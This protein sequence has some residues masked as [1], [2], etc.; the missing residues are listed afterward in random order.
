M[1]FFRLMKLF[2]NQCFS[3]KTFTRYWKNKNHH[4]F[5]PIYF[6]I[7]LFIKCIPIVQIILVWSCHEGWRLTRTVNQ[8]YIWY[9]YDILSSYAIHMYVTWYDITSIMVFVF[10]RIFEFIYILTP[11]KR[12]NTIEIC[13][14]YLYNKLR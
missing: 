13:N 9:L 4:N 14:I 11:L 3:I 7:L 8:L 12:M 6:M 2:K 10:M 1:I 5:Y